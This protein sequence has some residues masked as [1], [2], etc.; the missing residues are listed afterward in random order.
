MAH[1]HSPSSDGSQGCGPQLIAYAD[2]LGGSLRGLAE[3]L[4]GPLAGAFDGVHILPFYRPYDGAD[5]GFDPEDHTEPD[6]RLGTWQDIESL[7]ES[8]VVMS[9]VIVNH[10]SSR[11]PGFRDVVEHGDAS[12]HAGMYLTLGS[13]FPDGVTESDLARIYRPRPGLPFTA[14]ALGGRRRL[15]WTTFTPEQIDLDIRHP[16]TW[17]Y[18]T[19]VIDALTDAG[20]RLLRLDAVGYTGKSP[21]TDCFMTPASYDFVA[22]IRDYAA[23]RGAKVLLEIHG[24]HR[25]QIDMAKRVDYVYDFALPPLLIHALTSHDGGPL[26]RWLE[27]RPTN[28]VTVLDTHDGIGVIDAGPSGDGAGDDG[29]LDDSQ[30]DALVEAIHTNSGGTSRLAT[31][32]AASNLD[33][34]QVNCTFRDAL[35]DDARYLAARLMQLFVPGIPQVYYVGL[36]GGRNDV[37]L[38]ERTAVGRDINRHHFSQAEIDSAL[39]TPLVEAHLAALKFRAR[40]PAF[41]GAFTFSVDEQYVALTWRDREHRTT[42]TV[43]L[44]TADATIEA[45]TAMA[46][47]MVADPWKPQLM[48]QLW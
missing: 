7:S 46:T 20:V 16:G 35:G 41:R 19:S 25:Q 27:I 44:S 37:T 26:A 18:L 38:L 32:T 33:L 5:A 29:L 34:Y 14:M 42:L 40:H 43:D 13:V 23:S 31:G 22:R 30:L 47:T 15:V 12:P 1:A 45:T 4:R 9:D 48:G 11:S 24:H 28:A 36:L 6:P 21:G 10:V 39:A 2:R 3:L 17:R 8:H